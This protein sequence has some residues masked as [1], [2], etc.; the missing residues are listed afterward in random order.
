MTWLSI[1]IVC[2]TS[3]LLFAASAVY[4]ADSCLAPCARLPKKSRHVSTAVPIALPAGPGG[5]LLTTPGATLAKGSKRKVVVVE[6]TMTSG[7]IMLLPPMVLSMSAN[8][9][10][11]LME[12]GGAP[13]GVVTDCGGTL[14][15]PLPPMVG[16][17]LSATF[18]LDL[19]QAETANPG[20][21][22]GMPLTVTLTGGDVAGIGGPPVLVSMAVR[23]EGK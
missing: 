23:Q 19:D 4:A 21:L 1:R 13:M 9:N 22:I 14:M 2:M 10:G 20:V 16:C 18:W 6:A 8:V 15:G 3:V 17:T 7:G 11:V 12:P 5:V